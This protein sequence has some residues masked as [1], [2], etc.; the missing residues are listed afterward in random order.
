M[1]KKVKMISYLHI[2]VL[3]LCILLQNRKGIIIIE[4]VY[5]VQTI[6]LAIERINKNILKY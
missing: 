3:I 4:Y 1:A 5:M 6:M 2:I